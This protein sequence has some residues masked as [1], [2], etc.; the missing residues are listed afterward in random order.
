M[1][2]IKVNV[3]KNLPEVGKHTLLEIFNEVFSTGNNP[4]DWKERKVVSILKPG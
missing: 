3:L 1:D 2:G 4:E